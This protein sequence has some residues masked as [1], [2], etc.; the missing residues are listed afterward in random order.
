[1][2]Q[3]LPTLQQDNCAKAA[4]SQS[5]SHLQGICNATIFSPQLI[6][7]IS[8]L[9]D[10]K[11]FLFLGESTLYISCHHRAQVVSLDHSFSLCYVNK[12]CSFRLQHHSLLRYHQATA[13]VL[14][15]TDFKRLL[16]LDVPKVEILENFQNLWL[17]ALSTGL[18]VLFILILLVILCCCYFKRKYRPRIAF[19]DIG[20]V[21]FSVSVSVSCLCH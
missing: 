9:T 18:C 7:Q 2:D 16:D 12:G 6:T 3:T 21:E 10:G 14:R 19:A 17:I 8:E 11:M 4:L 1:M 5:S 13:E 15:G 20:E